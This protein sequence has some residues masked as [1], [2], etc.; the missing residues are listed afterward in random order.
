MIFLA[1]DYGISLIDQFQ[2]TQYSVPVSSFSVR[3]LF[4]CKPCNNNNTMRYPSSLSE[5]I[6][7]LL[8]M[9]WNP[10][11]TLNVRKQLFLISVVLSIADIL[12]LENMVSTQLSNLNCEFSQRH[13]GVSVYKPHVVFVEIHEN[14]K[15]KKFKTETT[16]EI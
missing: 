14:L 1:R 8:D 3:V 5:C 10:L 9:Y 16:H 12:K 4:F 7:R 15:E 2:C 11:Q 13:K 6:K